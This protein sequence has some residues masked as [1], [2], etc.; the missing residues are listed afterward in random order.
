MTGMLFENQSN[1]NSRTLKLEILFVSSF[2]KNYLSVPNWSLRTHC[3]K[4]WLTEHV[5]V[6]SWVNTLRSCFRAKEHQWTL[7]S[8]V[9]I[10]CFILKNQI[11]KY[12]SVMYSNLNWMYVVYEQGR[13]MFI[14][15]II[16]IDPQLGQSHLQMGRF[17]CAWE[18]GRWVAHLQMGNPSADL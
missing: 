14:F 3:G 18:I 16:I 15:I 11:K 2:N 13:N 7:T 9:L 10:M 17:Q 1:H 5:S 12:N 4:Q 8:N 6:S